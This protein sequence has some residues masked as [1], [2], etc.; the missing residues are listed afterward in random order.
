VWVVS[1]AYLDAVTRPHQVITRATVARGGQPLYG[2]RSLPVTGG[3][4]TVR[5]RSIVRRTCDLV[6]APRLP[7]DLFRDEPAYPATRTGAEPLGT[8]GQEITLRS[9]LVYSGGRTEWVPLGVFRIDD[10]AGSLLSRTGAQVSGVSRESWVV[11]DRF[12]SPRMLRGPSAVAIIRDLILESLPGADVAILTTADRR[13]PATVVDRDRWADGVQALAESIGCVVYADPTG[14]FVIADAPTLNSAPVFRFQAGPGG[15][16]LDATGTT[17]R[18][19]VYNAAVVTGDTPDGADA[20]VQGVAVDDRTGS[21]TRYGDPDSGGWGK[22]AHFRAVPSLTSRVQCERVAI[23]DVA[24]LTGVGT[25]LDLTSV[26][27]FP[28]EGGDVVDVVTDHTSPVTSISRHIVDE[29]T[30]PLVAGGRFGASTRN[31]GEVAA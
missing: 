13:V 11:D 18:D 8:D 30:I 24:Q 26:P 14:R 20:P 21:L 15:I 4:V 2:G 25:S 27:L 17:S 28:L 29:L 7:G 9:G 16:L 19:P 31:L 23:A 1:D 5:S 12:H 3:Q 22:K 6:I 10:V